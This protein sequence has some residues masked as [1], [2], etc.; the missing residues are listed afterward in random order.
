MGVIRGAKQDNSMQAFVR[1]TDAFPM[2]LGTR[3][4]FTNP[5]AG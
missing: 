3:S 5:Y 1:C 2:A 4:V